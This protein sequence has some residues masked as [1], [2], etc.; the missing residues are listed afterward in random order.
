M[1][2]TT[3]TTMKSR[4]TRNIDKSTSVCNPPT[5]CFHP[6]KAISTSHRSF[7]NSFTFLTPSIPTIL[8]LI[9]RRRYWED[10]RAVICVP[11]PYSCR[12][13]PRRHSGI[14]CAFIIGHSMTPCRLPTRF[15]P[16]PHQQQRR[17]VRP[18]GNAHPGIRVITFHPNNSV[19]GI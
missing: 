11:D 6:F 5:D 13:D 8:I 15:V 10:V 9:R 17:Q 14:I 3:T 19:P 1:M 18:I 7:G 16:L 4:S 2:S 12:V